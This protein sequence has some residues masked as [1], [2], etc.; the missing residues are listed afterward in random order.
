MRNPGHV[1]HGEDAP[2][3]RAAMTNDDAGRA[4]EREL[5]EAM[6][7]V[8]ALARADAGI[9][10]QAALARAVD[11]RF[12]YISRVEAG[13]ENLSLETLARITGAIGIGLPAFLE[14]VA[15]EI[16]EPT[17]LPPR[18]RGRPRG[19]GKARTPEPSD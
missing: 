18:R 7:R 10:T 8:I 11:V 1:R 15:R 2:L 6:G 14:R 19:G 13:E 9:A 4:A 5:K 12:Q 3:T 16:R 17:A